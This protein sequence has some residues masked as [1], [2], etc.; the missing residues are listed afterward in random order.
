MRH[1][2]TDVLVIFLYLSCALQ[3][4]QSDKACCSM[5]KQCLDPQSV[6]PHPEL[7]TNGTCNTLH[8]NLQCTQCIC[9]LLPYVGARWR[10]N[11]AARL[12]A[13]YWLFFCL[14]RCSCMTI[15]QGYGT[16]EGGGC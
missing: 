1:N 14:A 4:L 11:T 6:V 16:A 7:Y 2:S 3:L 13:F 10:A 15:E 9:C 8:S 12:P 5:D